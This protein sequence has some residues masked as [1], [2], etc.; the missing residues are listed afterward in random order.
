MKEVKLCCSRFVQNGRIDY[1]KYLNPAAKKENFTVIQLPQTIDYIHNDASIED[2]KAVN[3]MPTDR[4]VFSTR[5]K[6]SYE[7]VKV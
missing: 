2:D 7:Y 5:Q 6:D 3:E 4:F 1:L